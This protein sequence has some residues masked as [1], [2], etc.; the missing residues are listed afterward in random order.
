[1]SL[2]GATVLRPLGE[3]DLLFSA[4]LEIV[5]VITTHHAFVSSNFDVND[6]GRGLSYG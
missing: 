3:L 5:Y 6:L 1:M 4:P 2:N